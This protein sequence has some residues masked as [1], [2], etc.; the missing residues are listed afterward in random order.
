MNRPSASKLVIK[1]DDQIDARRRQRP[2]VGARWK[3]IRDR[4]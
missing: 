1:I 2:I 4:S 3:G